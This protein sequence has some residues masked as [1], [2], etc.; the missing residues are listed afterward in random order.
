MLL[1]AET[2]R[3]LIHHNDKLSHVC[4]WSTWYMQR[5]DTADNATTK[6][7]QDNMKKHNIITQGTLWKHI[8]RNKNYIRDCWSAGTTSECKKDAAYADSQRAS[9]HTRDPVQ[10]HAPSWY[11]AYMSIFRA[12][13]AQRR[14][15]HADWLR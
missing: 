2:N 3:A 10:T 4:R 5:R 14:T 7:H 8:Q 13:A 11:S 12:G 1:V 6:K 9:T 15:P